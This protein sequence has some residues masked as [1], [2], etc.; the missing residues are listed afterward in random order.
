MLIKVP[1]SHKVE[2]SGRARY[3]IWPDSMI[4]DGSPLLGF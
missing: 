3:Q 2:G 1:R 4:H